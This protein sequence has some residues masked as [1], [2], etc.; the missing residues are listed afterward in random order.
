MTNAFDAFD[1]AHETVPNAGL[2]SRVFIKRLNFQ[3]YI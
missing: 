1:F 3:R 2:K